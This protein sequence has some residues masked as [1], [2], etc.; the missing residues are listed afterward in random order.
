M[1][2]PGRT[3]TEQISRPSRWRR[4]ASL[5]AVLICA[6]LAIAYVLLPAVWKNYDARH[7]GFE[8]TPGLTYT[9]S[10]VPGDPVNVALIGS[11]DDVLRIMKAAK[12]PVAAKLGVSAD[13]KI[14]ADSVLGRPDPDAPVS[15]LTL[16]GRA[17]DL[18]FEQEVG[19]SPRHRHH[20]RFWQS[21]QRDADGRPTWVG[22]AVYDLHVGLSR[23]TGQITHVTAPD[24]DQERDFLFQSLDRTT[25]LVERYAVDGFHKMLTGKNGSGDPWR[26]DGRLFVGVINRLADIP[27]RK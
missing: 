5:A 16:F 8:N 25:D 1:G 15:T 4:W 11:R 6:Y 9:T 17:E 21:D 3:D 12:W 19:D 26:T 22:A 27:E 14:A 2:R 20:V 23:T 18:A 24:V 10:G 13:L 7:P